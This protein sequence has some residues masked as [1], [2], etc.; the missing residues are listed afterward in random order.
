MYIL[1][2]DRHCS[3]SPSANGYCWQHQKFAVKSQQSSDPPK[4][5]E[6][7]KISELPKSVELSKPAE[8]PKPKKFTPFEDR[9]SV[10]PERL[11]NRIYGQDITRPLICE[12][13][14]FIIGVIRGSGWEIKNLGDFNEFNQ[15]FK[16]KW[17]EEF[18]KFQLTGKWP[19]FGD[20]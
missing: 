17:K 19:V 12:F 6:Q 16:P 11:L 14:S 9:Y 7:V 13:E 10:I 18:E 2:S 20:I 8:L 1:R 15:Q 5:Q 3:R 4:Q